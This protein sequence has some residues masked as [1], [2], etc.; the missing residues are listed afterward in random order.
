MS[1]V[2]FLHNF[3]IAITNPTRQSL[4]S[5]PIKPHMTSNSQ[6]PSSMRRQDR[7]LVSLNPEEEEDVYVLT[8]KTDPVHQKRMSGLRTRYFPPHLL[9]VDAHVTLFHALPESLKSVITSDLSSLCAKIS[10]FDIRAAKPFRMGRGVGVHVSG[11]APVEKLC[12][13]LQTRWC[14][15]LTLQDSR[16][17]RGHYTLMNKVDDREVIDRC[18][19][20]LESDFTGCGGLATGLDLWR[21][22]RGWWRHERDIEFSGLSV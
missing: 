12:A 19:A 21:Y 13:E 6:K 9:K 4:I 16:K 7:A 5:H 11:L 8:L 10:P 15:H 3:R 2:L 18:L 17:F 1:R 22:D 20:E 14:E